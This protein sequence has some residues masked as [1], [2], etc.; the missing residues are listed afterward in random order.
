M[1]RRGLAILGVDIFVLGKDKM[2]FHVL[3]KWVG[4][5]SSNRKMGVGKT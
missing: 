2:V 5:N 1:L 4:G 3:W